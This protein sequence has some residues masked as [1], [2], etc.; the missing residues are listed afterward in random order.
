[1]PAICMV[2]VTVQ[3]TAASREE[4]PFRDPPAFF[5]VTTGPRIIRSAG[6]LSLSG[7]RHNGNLG[8]TVN[9]S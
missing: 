2:A 4:S 6:L 1:M 3:M 7:Y 9:R 5:L 8:Y